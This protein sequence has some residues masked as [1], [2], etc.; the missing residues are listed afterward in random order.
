MDLLDKKIIFLLLFI[1][2]VLIGGSYISIIDYVVDVCTSPR[3]ME[4]HVLNIDSKK[5][6]WF[7]GKI[8]W[9]YTVKTEIINTGS[10]G[11][12]IIKCNAYAINGTLVT[13][14]E[15]QPHFER[16][17]R[18]ELKFEFKPTELSQTQEYNFN[19]TITKTIKES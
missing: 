2:A 6:E 8:Y 19:I 13:Y 16:N 1:I 4:L 9:G 3:D 17:E 12:A 15:K 18:K 5:N 7:F 11:V 10:K 14:V